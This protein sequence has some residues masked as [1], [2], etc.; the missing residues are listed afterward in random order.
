M[1]WLQHKL[2]NTELVEGSRRT[3]GPDKTLFSMCYWWVM[4]ALSDHPRWMFRKNSIEFFVELDYYLYYF[5]SGCTL[6]S[7]SHKSFQNVLWS[8][9]SSHMICLLKFPH[10]LYHDPIM[11]LDVVDQIVQMCR[12]L[13]PSWG[14]HNSM[15]VRLM[16]ED[17]TWQIN[18]VKIM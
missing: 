1:D 12:K 4:I 16:W 18:Y 7:H 5:T 10:Y 15:Y 6:K 2:N 3:R 11:H 13:F 17:G 8:H 9:D 14:S